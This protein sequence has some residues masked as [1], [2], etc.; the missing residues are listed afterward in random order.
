MVTVEMSKKEMALMLNALMAQ[1]EQN[2]ACIERALKIIT[3]LEKE[4]LRLKERLGVNIEKE[5]YTFAYLR[6]A[7]A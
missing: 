5:P 1:A 4:N 2:D 6:E 7:V 3:A